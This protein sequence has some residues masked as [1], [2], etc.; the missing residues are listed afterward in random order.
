MRS[1]F[2]A[3]LGFWV[4]QMIWAFGVS[5]PVIYLNSLPVGD[6]ASDEP[7]LEWRD[8]LGYVLFG[9][10][11]IFEIAGDL[12]KNSFRADKSNKGKVCDVG[13][14]GWCRHPN[15]F[16]EIM[17]WWGIFVSC[18]AGFEA[19][20]YGEGYGTVASPIL[21][22]L[23]LLFLSG[24]P[25]AEGSSWGRYTKNPEYRPVVLEYIESVPPVV[26]FPSPVYRVLPGWCKAAFCCEF[27]MYAPPTEEEDEQAR[28]KDRLTKHGGGHG[29]NAERAE[30]GG[31]G[32]S[33]G[34]GD[35]LKDEGEVSVV[36]PAATGSSPTA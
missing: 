9:I 25:S 28:A 34:G 5:V 22:M 3:F 36:A 23:I 11:C 4:F 17:I 29:A 13:V 31:G 16:G 1:Q 12:T 10:G 19:S 33:S 20:G 18:T 8:Y 14:W 15:Y 26:P 2:F 35:N 7:P 24:V 21:T 27:P 6:G 32:G 30:G